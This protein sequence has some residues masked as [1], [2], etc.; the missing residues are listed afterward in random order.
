MKKSPFK[1]NT[2]LERTV[3]ND[4]YFLWLQ[5]VSNSST[6]ITAIQAAQL[7]VAALEKCTYNR[8]YKSS[9][10]IAK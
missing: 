6:S 4:F 10:L 2:I 5:S 1:D 8:D 3:D 7:G 9:V